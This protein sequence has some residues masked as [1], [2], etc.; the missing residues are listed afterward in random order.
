MFSPEDLKFIEDRGSDITTVKE[1]VKNF[2]NGFPYMEIIQA[3][4][5]GKGIIQLNQEHAEQFINFFDETLANGVTLLKFVPASGAASRMFKSLYAA[6]AQLEDGVE[7]EKIL[8]DV[9]IKKFFEGLKN[10]AFYGAMEKVGKK[11]MSDLT[12]L[13]L[14]DLVLTEKG[15]N[16]G[17]LPKGLLLF[18]KYKKKARTSFE[19]H[20]VEGALYAKDHQEKIKLH[21]TV[22]PEH[23][24]AFEEHFSAVK[25]HYET[26]FSVAYEVSFSQQKPSTDTIAVDLENE[27]FRNE[28]GSLLFRPGG[29]GALL[30]NLNDLNADVILLKTLIMLCLTT[31]RKQR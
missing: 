28:D 19:E 13:E 26:L 27:P 12:M 23:L 25:A 17:N 15:L 4:T 20:C 14:L 2:E 11:P 6:K 31:K 1:Q 7:E 9:D 22:S 21:F 30:D 16:Y 8:E 18:H 3:A 24:E 10:F 29:H 5:V